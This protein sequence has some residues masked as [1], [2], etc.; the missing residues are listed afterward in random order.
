[1][2]AKHLK[3]EH[4]KTVANGRKLPQVGRTVVSTPFGGMGSCFIPLSPKLRPK[5]SGQGAGKALNRQIEFL[6]HSDCLLLLGCLKSPR[7]ALMG[8]PMG[9]GARW[10]PYRGPLGGP[11]GAL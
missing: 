3:T 2:I 10:G 5:S 11:I 8:S 6:K 4:D 7:R 1:M 9:W